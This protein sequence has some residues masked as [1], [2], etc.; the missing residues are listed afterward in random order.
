MQFVV[1]AAGVAH[2]VS[3]PIAPPQGGGG[4]LAICTAGA[5]TSGSRLEEA[6]KREIH[7]EK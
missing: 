2:R 1:K 6:E 7:K 3:I 5:C 4:G